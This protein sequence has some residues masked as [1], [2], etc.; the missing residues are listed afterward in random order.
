M[1]DYGLMGALGEGVKSFVDS[2]RTER[3]YQDQKRKDAEEKAMKERAY[4]LQLMQS[5]VEEKS[6]GL[7]V[8]NADTVDKEAFGRALQE[9]SLAKGGQRVMQDPLSKKYTVEKI[10]GFRDP[11]DTLKKAQAGKFD[12]EAGKLRAETAGLLDPKADPKDADSLRSQWL[13]LPTTK[14]TQH[15]AMAWEK[16]QKSSETPTPAGDMSLIFAYMKMLDPS[17]TVREGEYASAKNAAGVPEQ[18]M[19]AYNK[20]R[21]GVILSP[22]QRTDFVD[23]AGKIYNAQIN[24]QERVD[25]YYKDLAQRRK[26]KP[27]DVVINYPRYDGPGL[28]LGQ[29]KKPGGGLINSAIANSSPKPGTTVLVNGQRYRVAAD[30][31]T[32]EPMAPQNP[33]GGGR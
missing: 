33:L 8:K 7:I 29:N 30:G 6:D 13:G 9:G 11:E 27:E 28:V 25:T 23:R 32:L 5:G 14:D 22:R 20:A 12:A 2:Y 31:D 17:S 4:K 19:N 3:S 21:D 1:V 24:A 18:I 26:V 15:L 16:I 10:P